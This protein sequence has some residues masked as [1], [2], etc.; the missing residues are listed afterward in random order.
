MGQSYE[1]VVVFEGVG[2]RTGA[3]L[4]RAAVR[5]RRGVCRSITA[6]VAIAR[7][8]GD[9]YYYLV[10]TAWPAEMEKLDLKRP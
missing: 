10:T 7:R 8:L 2:E 1:E 3:R 9:G 6:L 4:D 5:G